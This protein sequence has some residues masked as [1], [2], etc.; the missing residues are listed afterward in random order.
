MSS[1][2]DSHSLHWCPQDETLTCLIHQNADDR[3]PVTTENYLL[4]NQKSFLKR[5]FF[6]VASVLN[7]NFMYHTR[8]TVSDDRC[9]CAPQSSARFFSTQQDKCSLMVVTFPCNMLKAVS[10][11]VIH[12]VSSLRKLSW[13][14]RPVCTAL[15]FSS[16]L[17]CLCFGF[18]KPGLST[19]FAKVRFGMHRLCFGRS[20]CDR[21]MCKGWLWQSEIR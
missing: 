9:A 1:R 6:R 8:L 15:T 16:A 10:V 3:V 21:V 5:D 14:L 12:P 13:A 20:F 4:A 17:L 11:I 18:A 2:L 7:N 19:S